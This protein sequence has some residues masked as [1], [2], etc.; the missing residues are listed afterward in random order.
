MSDDRFDVIIAGGGLAGSVAAFQ[1]AKEGLEVLV[2][3]KG[4][5]CG[6]KNMTGGRLYSHTLEK[7]IPGFA[8]KAPLERRITK[9]RFTYQYGGKTITSDFPAREGSDSYAVLRSGFDT[10]MAQQAEEEGAMYVCG[11]R[12]DNLLIRHGQVCGIIAGGEEMESD[13][14]I[15]ADG[16]NSLLAQ[17]LGIREELRPEEVEIGAKEVIGLDASAIEERF[18]L[19][20]QEGI[21]WIFQGEE[22]FGQKGTGFVYTNQNSLSVGILVPA[23]SML[24]TKH[25][26]AD[27]VDTFKEHTQISPLLEGGKLLEYSAHLLPKGGRSR[28]P[29]LCGDGVLVIGDAAGLVA[30]HGYVVHGMDLAV[31]SACLAAETCLK[32]KV[33]DNF[34]A[35]TLKAYED[36]VYSSRIIRDMEQ[37]ESFDAH[38]TAAFNHT[39]E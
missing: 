34:D 23:E 15:L 20:P 21:S 38:V 16:V 12:V 32:A 35:K 27:L 19:N 3:E 1:L 29:R 30:N 39:K 28:I 31:E 2:V 9:D 33:A 25:G 26:I 4:N 7:L 5:T 11:I 36:A 14:V 37:A 17:K 8:Q 18:G 10:W 22:A 13:L 24:T 6:S